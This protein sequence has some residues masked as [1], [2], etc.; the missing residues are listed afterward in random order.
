MWLLCS[1]TAAT[2]TGSGGSSVTPGQGDD[3]CVYL[4]THIAI[5][6]V[7]PIILGLNEEN[8]SHVQTRSVVHC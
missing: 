4:H 3:L 6:I 2:S 8:P 7:I 5:G 1:F